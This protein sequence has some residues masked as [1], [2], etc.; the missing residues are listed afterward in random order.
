M[1]VIKQGA[2]WYYGSLVGGAFSDAVLGNWSVLYPSTVDT[3]A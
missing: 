1:W 2:D 3:W